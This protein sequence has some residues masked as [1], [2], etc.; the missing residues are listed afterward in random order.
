MEKPWGFGECWKPTCLK[1][2][3]FEFHPLPNSC[4]FSLRNIVSHFTG[5]GFFKKKT[6]QQ[7]Y[8]PL[9]LTFTVTEKMPIPKKGNES[10]SQTIDFFCR[11]F[12]S[13]FVSGRLSSQTKS[14]ILDTWTPQT[15]DLTVRRKHQF[16]SVLTDI[17][18][19]IPGSSKYVKFLPFGWF[20]LVK[21][22]KFY[23]LGR[24]RYIYTPPKTNMTI[25]KQ[26]P[27]EG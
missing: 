14:G 8:N 23:T 4:R 7:K 17:Y 24:S 2:W 1:V 25:E 20:F 19:Y 22:H 18:I 16:S 6:H 11:V 26:Q 21:R 27:F 12:N 9:Q 3:F 5:I 10:S 15:Q 13:T